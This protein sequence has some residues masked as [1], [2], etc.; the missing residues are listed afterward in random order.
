M[1]HKYRGSAPFFR[2]KGE[3]AMSGQRLERLERRMVRGLMALPDALVRRLAGAPQLNAAGAVLDVR[4]QL[5][6]RL[7]R[8]A[9][10]PYFAGTVGEA[11]REYARGL[12]AVDAPAPAGIVRREL[13]VAGAVGPRRAFLY[14]PPDA[15]GALP[16]L[17]YFHGGGFTVGTLEAY[18]AGCRTIAARA[19]IAV[20]SVD[21]RLAPEHRFPAAADDA[22]AA[23]RWV[24]AHAAELGVDPERLAVGG[25]SAGGNLSAVVCLRAR[26][27]GGPRPCFQWLI[28]PATDMTRALRSHREHAAGPFLD[29]PMMTWFL[30]QY[31]APSD[32]HRH[33]HASPLFAASHASLPPAHVVVAGFDPL[34]DEGLAY[35]D[36]LRTA[37]VPVSVQQAPTLVHGFLTMAGALP[38]ARLARDEA[39][40]ALG[41]VL[42]A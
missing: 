8:V 28:Y 31:L 16:T 39:I 21:Y 23:F 15:R 37:G 35:A 10:R 42:R 30:A 11:R 27:E 41:R 24:A 12:G 25:D 3:Q 2:G 14:T 6:A 1:S 38:V 9:S 34:R 7:H 22:L 19:G 18:D 32:D 5:L 40:D 33:P 4:A 20:V 36:A 26:D 29:E 17:V 13:S